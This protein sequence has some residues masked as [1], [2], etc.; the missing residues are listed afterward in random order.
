MIL[1]KLF[2]RATKAGS[3]SGSEAW[4]GLRSR[5]AGESVTA[6]SALT[7][8]AYYAGI[9][10]IAETL[11]MLPWQC[12][13]KTR[14][15]RERGAPQIEYM[16]NRRA[17]PEMSAISVREVLIAHA[18]GWGNG[19]AEIERD[20]ANRPIALWPLPP[21]RIRIERIGGRLSYRYKGEQGDETPLDPADVFHLHGLGFDGLSGYSLIALAARTI[22]GG[23]AAE[24]YANAFFGNA[25][26]ASGAITVPAGVQVTQESRDLLKKELQE[27]GSGRRA[28]APLF[29][30]GGIEWKPMSL[31]AQDA[32]LIEQ[33]KFS[34]TEMARW[35]RIPPHKLMDLDRS[36]NN[37][38]EHQGREFVD[39]AL[40]PWAVRLEQEADYKLFGATNTISY[41]KH[42]FRA[43]LRGDAASRASHYRELR[44]LGSISANEIREWEDLDPIGADGD[45]YVMQMN[46]TTL[47]KIGEDPAPP[48]PAPNPAPADPPPQPD[49][50][51]Q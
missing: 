30:P 34:I 37:N 11:A 25:V 33:R 20:R 42:N 45:K 24:N 46:M 16:L 6:D 21:D 51:P 7:Y 5:Q 41:T 47:E 29:L 39:D 31:P 43:L 50:N 2:A 10:I 15:G 9:R 12:Y 48:K 18:I 40:M 36:T 26:V 27:K 1:E 3:P 38:I 8:A 28:F 19:Y 44:N 14:A 32:Q 23:M 4:F 35:F 13:N 49:G 22:G 17:N